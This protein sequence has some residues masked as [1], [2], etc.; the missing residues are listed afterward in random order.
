MIIVSSVGNT[1]IHSLD[2]HEWS[3]KEHDV[4]LW[5]KRGHNLIPQNPHGYIE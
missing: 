2:D 3:V 5:A 4:R 1:A